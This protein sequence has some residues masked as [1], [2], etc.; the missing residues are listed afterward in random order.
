M[1]WIDREVIAR[2]R[3]VLI[4][5]P[6][7]VETG[8]NNLVYFSTAIWF[9]NPNCSSVTYTQANGRIH[10]PGQTAECRVYVPYYG[11]TTQEAQFALL[12][13]KVAAARQADGLDVTSALLAA[14]AGDNETTALAA[15]SVGQAIYHKL[16][17][18]TSGERPRFATG[19]RRRAALP[20]PL[21]PRTPPP[22]SPEPEEP[23]R[24]VV[25]PG[26]ARQ[27]ALFG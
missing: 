18:G 25:P 14:G 23:R 17:A 2:G 4:V 20:A 7:A 19:V 22:P 15:M 26:P 13:H 8:L 1:A 10:R 5:N 6:E 11:A 16:A 12:G 21:E 27:P 9:Q 24:A 3:R